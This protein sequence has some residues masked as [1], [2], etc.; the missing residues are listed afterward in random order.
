MDLKTFFDQIDSNFGPAV[1][2]LAL[3][4]LVLITVVDVVLRYIAGSPLVWAY[5]I[6]TLYLTVLIYFPAAAYT[7]RQRDNIALEFITSRLHGKTKSIISCVND[8]TAASLCAYLAFLSFDSFWDAYTQGATQGG[9]VVVP[10]WPSY[11]L[12][13]L[14]L[15]L[16]SV[17]MII[18]GLSALLPVSNEMQQDTES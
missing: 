6:T 15:S 11:A 9:L 10:L 14:G 4:S 13:P 12:V 3:G 17:R 1:S 16:L 2:A 7:Q 5:P 8:L 18:Q